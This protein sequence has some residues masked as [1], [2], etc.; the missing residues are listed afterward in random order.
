MRK[1]VSKRLAFGPRTHICPPS[2]PSSRGKGSL[3]SQGKALADSNCPDDC[4]RGFTSSKNAT[5]QP[6]VELSPQSKINSQEFCVHQTPE[7]VDDFIEKAMHTAFNTCHHHTLSKLLTPIHATFL[8]RF[9]VLKLQS[10]LRSNCFMRKRLAQAYRSILDNRSQ[11]QSR[12]FACEWTLLVLCLA[13]KRISQRLNPHQRYQRFSLVIEFENGPVRL[14]L[15]SDYRTGSWKPNLELFGRQVNYLKRTIGSQFNTRQALPLINGHIKDAQAKGELPKLFCLP[16]VKHKLL[17]PQVLLSYGKKKLMQLRQ[18]SFGVDTSEPCKGLEVQPASKLTVR[19]ANVRSLTKE[20]VNIIRAAENLLG[21]ASDVSIYVES[22]I[23]PSLTSLSK[24]KQIFHSNSEQGRGGTTIVLKKDIGVSFSETEIP[25]TVVLVIH[26]DRAVVILA[27]TYLSHRCSD[28]SQTIAQILDVIDRLAGRFNHPTVL[29]FGDFNMNERTVNQVVERHSHLLARLDLK[30]AENYKSPSGFPPLTTRRGINRHNE[31]VYSRLDYIMTN[32]SCQV[33]TEFVEDV[34]DHILF[35]LDLEL[36]DSSVK[37]VLNTDRNKINREIIALEK[38]DITSVLAFIKHNIHTYKNFKKPKS[39]VQSQLGF[40]IPAQRDRLL[41]EW[42]DS[43]FTF[44][45]SAASLRFT[46]FQGFAFRVIRS[47]T[48]YDQFQKRDGSIIKAVKDDNGDIINDPGCVSK[49]LID[50]L[51]NDD[52]RFSDRRYCLWKTLPLLPKLTE[53]ELLTILQRVSVHK[54]L[55][56]FPVPDEFIKHLL[57]SGCHLSLINLWN[58][59]TL[60]AFPE[61]FS[62]RLIPLNKVHPQIPTVHQMRPI[63]ALKFF[64]KSWSSGFLKNFTI[65][66]GPFQD[67]LCRN[68]AF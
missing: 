7:S 3:F 29:L 5:H 35:N 27:G 33:S 36:Q 20:K 2:H 9:R 68:L 37:R 61:I 13:H 54:A 55:T 28:K 17:N 11:G 19:M 65:N 18:S 16:W 45:Q 38:E 26:R 21:I 59:A 31:T 1:Q 50:H 43:Y 46:T 47:V 30:F 52:D 48:K 44:A 24:Y 34:S 58:P 66:S 64:S 15:S 12:W 49:A 63:V 6:P 40:V 67:S 22:R 51:R 42:I 25:D 10:H 14:D 62:C 4:G 41:K 39:V 23:D 56:D 57:S 53:P 32:G 60:E 8:A